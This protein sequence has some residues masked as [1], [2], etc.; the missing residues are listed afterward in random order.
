MMKL[1]IALYTTKQTCITIGE[2]NL[3]YGI[4]NKCENNLKA[5]S[6][7]KKLY[8]DMQ[9]GSE[10]DIIFVELDMPEYHQL[11][12]YIRIE[13]A[14]RK[15]AIVYISPSD[16]I[17]SRL[18]KY[19]PFDCI[20]TPVSYEDFRD[21]LDRYIYLNSDSTKILEYEYLKHKYSI[22]IAKIVYL[23]KEGRNIVIHT[24]NETMKFIGTICDCMNKECLKHFVQ[25]H[26]AYI[27]NPAHIK[28]FEKNYV[29][30]SGDIK[31]PVSRRRGKE[32][33][34]KEKKK[35]KKDTKVVLPLK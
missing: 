9:T 31:V 35:N 24:R 20:L 3:R 5:F 21:I 26:S 32:I 19:A 27:V 17:S 11:V 23:H 30:L 28:H 2:H 34:E 6:D 16:N 15:T 7:Y 8:E 25:T 4:L 12:D 29:V 13:L 18:I 33:K 1:D 14:N 22:E 10:Y